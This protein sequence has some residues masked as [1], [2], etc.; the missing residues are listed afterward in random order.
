MAFNRVQS[1]AQ[2]MQARIRACVR[3]KGHFELR[4]YANYISEAV[5]QC[6]KFTECVFQIS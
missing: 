5:K 1:I 4:Q 3:A 6:S 2:L